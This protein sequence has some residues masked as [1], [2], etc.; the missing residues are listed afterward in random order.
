MIRRL[1]ADIGFAWTMRV[2]ALA[3]LGLLAVANAVSLF[4][5]F[6][7][8]AGKLICSEDRP[9]VVGFLPHQQREAS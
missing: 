2:L 8:G 4:H 5:L 6:A 7:T 1:E 9:S 3:E